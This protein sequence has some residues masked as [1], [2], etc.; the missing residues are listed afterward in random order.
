MEEE[1]DIWG[2]QISALP[3][4]QRTNFAK[5]PYCGGVRKNAQRLLCPVVRICPMLSSL[6]AS[7]FNPLD[8]HI[9]PVKRGK[10]DSNPPPCAQSSIGFSQLITGVRPCYF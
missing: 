7:F 4:N 3:V 6:Y 9:H 5:D 2:F 8:S 10:G 1:R